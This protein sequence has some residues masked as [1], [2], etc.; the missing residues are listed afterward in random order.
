VLTHP[1]LDQLGQLERVPLIRDRKTP[2]GSARPPRSQGVRQTLAHNFVIVV[3][4]V[5]SRN[6]TAPL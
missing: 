4:D 6:Y 2:S 1:M 5:E 3:Y